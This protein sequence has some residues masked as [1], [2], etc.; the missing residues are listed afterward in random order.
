M[1][2][3]TGASCLQVSAPGPAPPRPTG[4]PTEGLV[5]DPAIDVSPVIE[6]LLRLEEQIDLVPGRFRGVGPMDEILAD[7][8]GEPSADTTR[9]GRHR[10][11]GAHQIPGCLDRIRSLEHA[12]DHRARGDELHQPVVER[13]AAVHR[14]VALGKLTIDVDQPEPGSLQTLALKGSENLSNQAALHRVGL[15]DDQGVLRFRHLTLH[16]W[17]YAGPLT[18]SAG[19]ALARSDL[20]GRSHGH[21]A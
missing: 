12:D 19:D 2:A 14:I 20:E 16:S 21:D 13:F 7:F 17:Q 10:I 3:A 8:E 1:A 9:S 15:D 4:T 6:Y 11:G 5:A 18:S